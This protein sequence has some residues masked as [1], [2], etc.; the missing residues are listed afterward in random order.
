MSDPKKPLRLVRLAPIDPLKEPR[1]ELDDT[2]DDLFYVVTLYTA[3]GDHEMA[4]AVA[5]HAHGLAALRIMS[6]S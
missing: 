3:A 4:R 6:R 5:K 2:I 1:V